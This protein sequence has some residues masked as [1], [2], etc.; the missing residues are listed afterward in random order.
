MIIGK[1]D[2]T[3]DL[4]Q[5]SAN[6]PDELIIA[7]I[8][9]AIRFDLKEVLPDKIRAKVLLFA[10]FTA[11]DFALATTYAVGGFVRV[12]EEDANGFLIG[13]VYKALNAGLGSVLL[14]PNSGNGNWEYNDWATFISEFVKPFLVI[15]AFT[16]YSKQG[17]GIETPSGTRVF[18]EDQSDPISGSQHATQLASLKL[19]RGNYAQL[20]TN[21]LVR[22]KYVIDG[23]SYAIPR[24]NMIANKT[25]YT[26]GISAI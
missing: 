17:G 20:I 21:E 19:L 7:P 22:R 6:T 11:T 4:V 5:F 13:K 23:V 25:A 9:N 15:A 10:A 16:W 8:S 12:D 26:G 2:F 3:S 1:S 14:A 24:N 18:R